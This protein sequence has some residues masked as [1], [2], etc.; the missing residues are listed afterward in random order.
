MR[1]LVFA[2]TPA[3]VHVYKHVVRRLQRGGHDV[4]VAGRDYSVTA[5]LLSYYDL[6]YELYGYCDTSK[7]SLFSNL[8]RHY[9]NIARLSRRFRPDLVFGMGSYSAHSSLVS[10]ASVILLRDSEPDGLDYRLSRPFAEAVLTPATF[11]KD[12]G[13]GHYVFSGFKESAYLHPDVFSPDPG[14]RDHL[15]LGPREP[16]AVVRLNAFGSHHD[17][18]ERGFDAAERRRLIERLARDATVLVSDEAGDADL[19]GLPARP[20]DVH[21]ARYHHVLD[22]ATLVVADT[23][24]TVT[25]AALLGTPAIRSNS[26][27]G[28]DDMGNFLA[29]EEAGLVRNVPT[30]EGVLAT[31]DELLG[32]PGTARSWERRSDA[33]VEGTVN[34]TEV[35]VRV[36]AG[37]D[38]LDAVSGLAPWAE[39]PPATTAAPRPTADGELL[40]E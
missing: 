12:L 22:Q 38:D 2:N 28:E 40:A 25:E 26:F 34:L 8:P 17:V 27:V 39:R 32:D 9:L 10:G 23:Q 36:A 19:R 3:H 1:V 21:P 37:H 35:L 30:F 7:R 20:L 18:G 16:F 24:T 14:V 6:P 13:D 15:G 5:S 33:F 4:L 29:L 31:V 11:R